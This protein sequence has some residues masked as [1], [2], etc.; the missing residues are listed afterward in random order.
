[1]L[2]PA[3]NFKP[4]YRV[5]FLTRE[6]WTR[7]TGTPAVV[8]FTEGSSMKDGTGVYGQSSV[9]RRLSTSLGRCATV[10]QAEI[11]AILDYANEIQFQGRPEKHVSICSVRQV[12]LQALQVVRTS[13]LVQQCQKALNDFSVWHAVGLYWVPGVQGK[14]IDN[15]FAKDSSFQKFVG[16]EPALEVARQSMRRRI[17]RTLVNQHWAWWR[18][19]DNTQHHP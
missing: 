5:T 12:T 9:G 7:G 15:K 11:Y 16:P 4:N 10:L 8:W 18:I 3:F 13:P 6:E 14:E 17:R 19:L 1:M 2:R